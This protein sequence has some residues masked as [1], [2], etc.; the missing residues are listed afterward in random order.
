LWPSIEQALSKIWRSAPP[1]RLDVRG[2]ERAVG[3]VEID[4]HRRS[5]SV[6]RGPS[7]RNSKT[8]SRH[9][10]L[11]SA[12]PVGLDLS[13]VLMP[14]CFFDGDLDRQAVRESPA[15]LAALDKVV[16]HWS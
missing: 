13:L 10:A 12:D 9:V 15:A 7:S 4:P 14:S 6:R 11:N 3:V 2:V 8:D 1:H 16:P 5:A